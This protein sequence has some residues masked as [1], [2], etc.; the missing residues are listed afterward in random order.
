MGQLD[1]AVAISDHEGSADVDAEFL[2]RAPQH[3][4]LGFAAIAHP[5][6]GGLAGRGMVGTVVD[7]VEPGSGAL[8]FPAKL[9]VDP[10]DQF[11]AEVAAR[12]PGLVGHHDGF[13]SPPV[14]P[15]NGLGGP[16]VDLKAGEMV[17]VPDLFADGAVSI[18]EGRDFSHG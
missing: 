7:G 2:G 8:H 10:N 9:G 17:H 3:A 5:A 15:A 13:H 4:R 16:G 6:I 1:V 11:L 12:H 18:D 14:E